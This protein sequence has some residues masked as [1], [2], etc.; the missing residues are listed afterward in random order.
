MLENKDIGLLVA[1]RD[2]TEHEIKGQIGWTLMESIRE[3]GL[4]ELTAMC[5]GC[6]SCATCH[7][8]VAPDFLDRLPPI[9]E[10]EGDLLDGS[11]NRN[12]FSRLSCQVPITS[13]L[14]GMKVQIAPED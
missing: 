9:G 12:E 13:D 2:G 8:Y 7:V 11:G 10:D 5:G 6:C 14:E 1:E 3:A 4:S